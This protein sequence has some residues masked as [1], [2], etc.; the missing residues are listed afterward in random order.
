MSV[1]F[2][3]D[4]ALC[5]LVPMILSVGSVVKLVASFLF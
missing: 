5:I 3:C 1:R 4:V 2:T